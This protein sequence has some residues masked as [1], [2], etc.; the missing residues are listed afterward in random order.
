MWR[1]IGV[2]SP[3]GDDQVGWR[4][5]EL[6][7][8]EPRDAGRQWETCICRNPAVELM[9]QLQDVA[10][11]VLVDAQRT[12]EIPGTVCRYEDGAALVQGHLFSSHGLG[13]ADVLRLAD[14]LGTLP[15]PLIVYGIEA[16]ACAPLSDLSPTVS[17]VLPMVRDRILAD[18]R[19]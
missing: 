7:Q 6:L 2:G 10:G 3:S 8:R 19:S 12:G 13:V 1:V 14:A 15:Q 16:A 18:I 4:V 5:V 11:V 9:P 17:A